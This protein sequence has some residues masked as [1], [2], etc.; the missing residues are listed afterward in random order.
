MKLFR[1]GDKIEAL[2]ED[3]RD[4]VQATFKHRDV[5]FDDGCGI[6]EGILV[7]ACD[8]CDR[9][10]VMP[11]QSTPALA[12]ARQDAQTPLEVTLDAWE[13]EV[14]DSA[15]RRVDP[16]ADNSKLRERLIAHFLWRSTTD[17]RHRAPAQGT[18]PKKR[19]SKSSDEPTAQES[20]SVKLAP[21]TAK[22]LSMLMESSGL[23]KSQIVGGVISQI[24][25]DLVLPS[26]PVG[27]E[28]FREIAGTF[29]TRPLTAGQSQ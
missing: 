9:A 3:C 13:M 23:S 14:L 18:R 1:A 15:A 5:P 2:C 8:R 27:M 22:C 29:A 6:A 26:N 4:T 11:A 12:C 21:G 24:E 7:A 17:S 25:E 20:L 16:A 28:K 10:I 19:K